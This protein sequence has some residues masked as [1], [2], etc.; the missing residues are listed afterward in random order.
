[1]RLFRIVNSLNDN[2]SESQMVAETTEAVEERAE[3]ETGEKVDDE[4]SKSEEENRGL[5]SNNL[6]NESL[7][8][9]EFKTEVVE[10]EEPLNLVQDKAETKSTDRTEE[11][12]VGENESLINDGDEGLMSESPKD[13]P[14]AE[15]QQ[16][17][18][19]WKED[20][21]DEEDKSTSLV[22]T[23]NVLSGSP[24]SYYL[25]KE[26]NLENEDEE[27]EGEE[28]MM[29]L[30]HSPPRVVK[31]KMLGPEL[32]ARIPNN[33]TSFDHSGSETEDDH[34]AFAKEV[35]A[36]Y[37]DRNLEFK[38]PKFYKEDLNLLK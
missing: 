25:S 17:M 15:T 36:F 10:R 18:G 9:T 28:K 22:Q 6:K 38:H 26:P 33:S 20:R 37:R 16:K 5:E 23:N 13:Q 24:K 1:M 30:S 12:L 31:E 32:G 3:T 35:E 19:D 14:S 11:S 2:D 4:T 34:L 21:S 29:Y 8:G 7:E 27:V